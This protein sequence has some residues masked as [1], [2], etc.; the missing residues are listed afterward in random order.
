MVAATLAKIHGVYKWCLMDPNFGLAQFSLEELD[1]VMKI[2]WDD[3]DVQSSL[4]FDIVSIKK[5]Q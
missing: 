4:C 2:I 5:A 3:Y 1:T